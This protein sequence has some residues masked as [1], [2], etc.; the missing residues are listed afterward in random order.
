MLFNLV[1]LLY[2]ISI[3]ASSG[4]IRSTRG[5]ACLSSLVERIGS[6]RA[7]D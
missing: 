7:I 6:N 4:G 3:I 2:F 5:V 1:S